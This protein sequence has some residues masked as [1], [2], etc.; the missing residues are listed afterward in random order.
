MITAL[1]AT[2]HRGGMG[3]K[4]TLPWYVPEDLRNFQTLTMNHIVVMGRKT[5]DD[6]KFPKPLKGRTCYVV[7]NRPSTLEH[8]AHPLDGSDVRKAVLDLEVL[9]STNSKKVY[10]IGGPKLI[11]DCHSV[12]DYVYLTHIEGTY[13]TDVKIN[14]KKLLAGF[15]PVRSS[16]APGSKATFIQYENLFKRLAGSA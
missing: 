11:M 14:L 7:T 10:I 15:R 9:N 3:Y 5:W 12:L 8:S 4:G 1:L 6:P 16:H 13:S 2:D